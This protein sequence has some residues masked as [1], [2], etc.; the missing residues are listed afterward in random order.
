MNDIVS[1]SFGA[2]APLSLAEVLV[3]EAKLADA[4]GRPKV[5]LVTTPRLRCK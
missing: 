1:R 5:D 2:A 4:G 3:Y